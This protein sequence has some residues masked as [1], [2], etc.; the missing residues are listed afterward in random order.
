MQATGCSAGST[1]FTVPK[2][3]SMFE[4][5]VAM[6]FIPE[7]QSE[8]TGCW[9][10]KGKS[11]LNRSKKTN[12]P[13]INVRIGGKHKTLFA[14]RVMVAVIEDRPLESKEESDHLCYNTMCIN[15]DH[16]ERVH[17]SVN[18]QR[19]RKPSSTSGGQ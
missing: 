15:P 11:T 6:S 19:R 7:G 4:R 16:L 18:R 14:H 1:G 8:L 17:R 5:L 12:Y 9:H 13:R 3:D 10:W 2:Y